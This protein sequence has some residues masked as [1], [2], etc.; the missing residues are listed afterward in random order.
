[1]L[2]VNKRAMEI[3][4]KIIAQADVLGVEVHRMD[5]GATV[6]DMGVKCPG[7]WRAASLFCEATLGGLGQ[8][9]Y[10]I[11][12]LDGIELP[13]VEI[14]VENPAI[15]LLG[16]QISGWP[17]NEFKNADGVVPLISGPVR[18]VVAKDMFAE[19]V[20]YRDS[21]EEVVVG[22]QDNR[23]PDERI[24]QSIADKTKLPPDKIYIL[25][26]AT[27]SL[28][29]SINVVSRTLETAIWRIHALGL[30]VNQ[31][32]AAWGKAPVPPISSDEFTAMV[33]TNTYTYYGGTV[34]FILNAEDSD[35]KEMLKKY[36]LA[37]YTCDY[38]G[39]PFR[40]LLEEAGGDIFN[41]DGFVHNV[42]KAVINNVK[43]GNIFV[44]GAVDKKMLLGCLDN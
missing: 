20:P 6:I 12:D 4:Q 31:I 13:Q 3:V 19:P 25:V 44:A 18:A 9:N 11:F 27:S 28:V 24:I 40:K 29:G 32:V 35:I 7:G 10:S 15:A 39:V 43:S 8:V 21:A 33:R 38:Y 22:L 5:S 34:G 17:L 1:M 14:Y 42:T 16:S 36:P 26:A 37:P 2:S 41:L 30:D 23:L